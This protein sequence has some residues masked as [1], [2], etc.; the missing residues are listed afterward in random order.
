MN[1]ETKKMKSQYCV[2]SKR[3]KAFLK[4]ILKKNFTLQSSLTPLSELFFPRQALR[5]L[6]ICIKMIILSGVLE[7]DT[8]TTKFNST[9]SCRSGLVR[10]VWLL[11]LINMNLI[12]NLTSLI[13]LRSKE[14]ITSKLSKSRGLCLL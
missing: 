2:H 9:G 14:D 7:I 13:S 6:C 12:F 1:H 11:Y 4:V 3:M 8:W 5:Y 10:K